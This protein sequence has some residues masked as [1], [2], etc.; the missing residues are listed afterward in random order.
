[1]VLYPVQ[2]TVVLDILFSRSH[3]IVEEPNPSSFNADDEPSPSEIR[4]L[5]SARKFHL[6]SRQR[7]ADFSSKRTIESGYL[8]CTS[9][10]LF[11]S[12]FAWPETQRKWFSANRPPAWW[13]SSLSI[14]SWRPLSGRMT[15]FRLK[16]GSCLDRLPTLTVSR[17]EIHSSIP[18]E[19]ITWLYCIYPRKFLYQLLRLS[20][21]RQWK[22]LYIHPTSLPFYAGWK[23]QSQIPLKVWFICG[24]IRWE[25]LEL[26]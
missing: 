6:Y 19:C 3:P 26:P 2:N 11:S 15:M 24:V 14:K 20:L 7:D 21:N 12:M 10:C 25:C 23:P 1:M 17:F 22:V 5:S 8:A 13:L 16:L 4:L 9:A 18:D